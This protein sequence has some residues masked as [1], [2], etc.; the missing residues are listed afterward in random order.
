[1]R[2]LPALLAAGVLA[3]PLA[4]D[5]VKLTLR[6]PSAM[7]HDSW[8]MTTG[9]P[10]PK[11]AL[12]SAG[13]VA[14][15]DPQGKPVPIQARV[16][17][18]WGPK[19]SA[20]W[21]LLDFQAPLK[22]PEAQYTLRFGPDVK[23]LAP[24]ADHSVTTTTNP[25]GDVD[26]NT[27]PLQ[28]RILRKGFNGL[29][30]V[31]LGGGGKTNVFAAKADAG[32]CFVHADGRVFRSSLGQAD[33]LEIEEAGALRTVVRAR[34]WFYDDKGAKSCQY[35]V[36]F[37]FYAGQ[38]FVKTLFTFLITE[39]TGKAAFRDIR[40]DWPVPAEQALF[41]GDPAGARDVKAG[42]GAYLLQYDCDKLAIKPAS[43]KAAW[44]DKAA[45][46]RSPGW[47][48]AAGPQAA[49]TLA[50]RDFWQQF[51]KEFGVSPVN[52][53][54]FH[55]WPAH[56]VAKPGRKIE[57][58]NIQYLW[59]VHEG[60]TLDF[61]VPQAFHAYTGEYTEY[62]YRYLRSSKD[63]NVIGLAKT[64]ELLAWFHPKTQ[65]VAKTV[66]AW[67]QEPLVMASPEWMCASGVFGKLHPVDTKRFPD[68][69]A[70]LSRAWDT[71]RRLQDLTRDYGMF[72]FGDGH[73]TWDFSKD[74]WSDVYRCWRA[75]HHGAPRVPWVL[76]LRSGDPKYFYH[77]VRNARFLMD[78]GM[79]NYTTPE[80]D[81]LEYPKGKVLGG[82]NDY[83]GIVPWHSGS[84][85]MDYNICM[86]FVLYYYYMT[87]DHRGLDIATMWGESVKKKYSAPFGSRSAAGTISSLVEVYKATWDPELKRIA[88][89]L[90]N[91]FLDKVQVMNTT[92][93]A[94]EEVV[95]SVPRFKDKPMPKGAFVQWENYAPWIEAWYDLTGDKKTGERI[96]AWADAYL[97]GWGDVW[98]GLK[99]G[100][101]INIF[102]YAWFVTKDAKYLHH[103]AYLMDRF[104]SSIEKSPGGKFDG[105]AHIGQ[106]SL[107]Y[108]YMAQRIPVLLAALAA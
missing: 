96:A 53:L 30:H 15:F 64:H 21:L 43:E 35:I 80:L 14:L 6:N 102:A 62:Q 36:R 89:D 42:P 28:A 20:R 97:E 108:G 87:G 69:E 7:T 54:S 61:T 99:V 81:K 105:F 94:N 72:I 11:D 60:E 63:A 83:K 91:H 85:L 88:Q 65:S 79:C 84:R 98:T 86:D 9:V 103:G 13:Q 107:G 26:V 77:G 5:E 24:A 31:I 19:A 23:P 44:D 17:S 104:I 45:P 58:A 49:L 10:F 38:P 16:A 27:G 59:F 70:G 25:D 95:K 71:E 50:C 32:P 51:P 90:V 78:I 22:G 46:A 3:A 73:T 41:G 75:Y 40:F 29:S 33:S 18:T 34:G 76:Y 68:V 66:E 52:G 8:P 56:G 4:A 2:L 92:T 93:P 57:D 55:V 67:Q 82:L 106:T 48:T 100:A 12:T 1:M 39:P 74:R 47:V 101:E 37:H